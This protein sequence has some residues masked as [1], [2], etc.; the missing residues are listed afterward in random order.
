M[1]VIIFAG[2]F[3]GFKLD[4]K[5]KWEFPVFTV[6]LSLFSVAAA[7]YIVIKDFIK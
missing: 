3:G 4:E 7:I 5:L 1:G 2:V 6:I